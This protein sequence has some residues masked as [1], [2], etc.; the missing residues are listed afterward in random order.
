MLYTIVLAV[1]LALVWMIFSGQLTIQGF[2]I[3]YIFG[4][5]VIIIVRNN[6]RRDV[7]VEQQ[8]NISGIP[9]QIA[10]LL[11]YIVR[12]AIDVL[13]S[14]LDVA[15]RVIMPSLPILPDVKR[16]KT[17]DPQNNELVS[18][19]SA[20][21]ITIT[22]GELVIDY[23]YENNETYMLVHVLDKNEST[24]EK[25]EEAQTKR[26]RLIQQIL[27]LDVTQEENK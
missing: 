23:E 27:G 9:Q 7:D 12:L 2:A 13:L 3:G 6:T 20:H 18:A 11:Y 4:F 24:Q 1:P 22:P 15:G 26:L 5:A 19:L 8:L 21:S 10:Y 16:I 14:G 17:Q 25:L